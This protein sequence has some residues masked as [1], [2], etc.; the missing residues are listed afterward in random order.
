MQAW[1]LVVIIAAIV[2]PAV[3][4]LFRLSTKIA[5]WTSIATLVAIGLSAVLDS[6]IL[7]FCL[8]ISSATLCLLGKAIHSRLKKAKLQRQ[9]EES[10]ARTAETEGIL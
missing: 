10:F 3:L 6:L 1:D 8:W 4:V 9:E 5:W 2:I 7:F